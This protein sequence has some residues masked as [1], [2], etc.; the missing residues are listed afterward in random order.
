MHPE[1]FE[2]LVAETIDTIPEEVFCQL[3]N[4]AFCVEDD[5]KVDLLGLY[6]G[7]NRVERDNSYAG[8]LPDKI[9]IYRNSVLDEVDPLDELAV[10]EEIRRTLWHEIAHH[11]GWEDED[12]EAAEVRRGWRE[13]DEE[14]KE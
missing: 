6:E 3:D 13:P 5:E 2:E 11:L 9:T 4:V 7:T 14:T 12:I 8:S 1:R 10:R